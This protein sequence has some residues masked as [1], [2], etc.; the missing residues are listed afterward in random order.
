VR[1]INRGCVSGNGNN[2]TLFTNTPVFYTDLFYQAFPKTTIASLQLNISKNIDA[3]VK[4]TD[5]LDPVDLATGNFTY[6][7]TF[8][9]LPGN[10]LDYEFS[11][12]YQSQAQ[13]DGPA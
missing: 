11:L 2:G 9:R 5:A 1:C 4:S 7:N 12:S 3:T 8:L 6:G 13:Y 10:T